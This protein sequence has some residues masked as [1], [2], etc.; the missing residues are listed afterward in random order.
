MAREIRLRAAVPADLATLCEIDLDASMLF[1]RAGLDLEL[2]EDHEFAVAERARW[3]RCLATGNS[4]LAIDADGTAVAFA[5]IGERDGEA[6]LDQ[7]SV[8]QS[9]MRRGIGAL[10]LAAVAAF[11]AKHRSAL[12][13]TTYEHLSWNRR[14]YERHGFE[15]VPEDQCGAEMLA[16]LSFERRW[17]PEPQLRIAMRRV[18]NADHGR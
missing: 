3:Q 6:Y 5:T 4:L 12:W 8:R 14:Y 2:T 13:L 15:R 9:H 16:E 11:A 7:L 1:V 10:L 17:L 18:A